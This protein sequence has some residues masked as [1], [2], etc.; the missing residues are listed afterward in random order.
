MLTR[1]IGPFHVAPIA[2]GCMNFNHAY[3]KLPTPERAGRLLLQA[4][5][6]GVTLFDTAALYL[7]L[8]HI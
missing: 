3:G 7:S 1:R 4:L 2:M 5:D 8:I 6:A